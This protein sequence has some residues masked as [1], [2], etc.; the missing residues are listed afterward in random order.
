MRSCCRR[1]KR[2]RARR[3]PSP[4]AAASARVQACCRPLATSSISHRPGLQLHLERK[5]R[6]ARARRPRDAQDGSACHAGHGERRRGAR[7][8]PRGQQRRPPRRGRA[9]AGAVQRVGDR[10]TER[11]ARAG[12]CRRRRAHHAARA[13]RG[14]QAAGA[15]ARGR[16]PGAGEPRSHPRAGRSDDRGAGL[17][18]ARHP[19]ARG[20]RPRAGGR[21]QPQGHVGVRRPRWRTCGLGAV[22]DCR[23]RHARRGGAAR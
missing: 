14:R 3:A 6:L 11:A 13:G 21:L 20:H 23:R 19:A 8:H 15:G 12:L 10:R 17:R 2:R 16:A 5:G 1:S 9:A 22:H 4:R 7:G 18:L